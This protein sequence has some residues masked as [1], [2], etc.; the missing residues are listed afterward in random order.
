VELYLRFDYRDGLAPLIAL[1][2]Q[3]RALSAPSST[4]AKAW[5]RRDYAKEFRA[6][7]P[8]LDLQRDGGMQV[9]RLLCEWK[10]EAAVPAIVQHLRTATNTTLVTS[11]LSALQAVASAELAST[12][13]AIAQ[14]SEPEKARLIAQAL[15][16]ADYRV[17]K[18]PSVSQVTHSVSFPSS[19]R[20]PSSHTAPPRRDGVRTDGRWRSS[21]VHSM[22]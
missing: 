14:N 5:N 6:I 8:C 2:A 18:Q 20:P 17:A 22:P 9:V 10:D 11:L 13:E 19:T 1:M 15:Q 3:N 21:A 16:Y 7:L 4:L 12:I